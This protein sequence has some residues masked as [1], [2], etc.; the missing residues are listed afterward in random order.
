MK[1]KEIHFVLVIISFTIIVA[2]GEVNKGHPRI[3][4]MEGGEEVIQEQISSND[5]WAGIHR[6][7]IEESEGMLQMEPLE[8]K[9]TGRRLL[10][11]SR[12]YLRRIFYL[13]YAYRMTDDV[14]FAEHAE[15]HMLKAAGFPDWNPSHF[16]DVGEMTMAI[17]IG[18]DWL[19]HALSD[20]SKTMI[21][22]AIVNK[23]IEPSFNEEYNWFLDAEHN[24]NQVCNAGMAYGAMAVMEDYPQLAD[25][26]IN[27]AFETIPKAMA[28]YQ[29]DG[30]YPEGYSYWGYGTTFNVLFLSV[31]ETYFGT[32]RGLSDTPGF[33]ETAGFL[34]H[35][36]APSGDCF[37]WGDCGSDG[38]LKPAMF[39]FAEK[40]ND[41]SLLWMEK[42]FLQTNDFTKFTRNRI[43][44]AIMVWGR[45]IDVDEI[46]P[47]ASKVWVGQGKNPVGLMRTSWSDNAMYLG[48]KVGSPSVNHGHMDIGSFVFENDGIRWAMDFGLQGYH[49][50]ESKGMN[51][52]GRTQDAERWTIFRL[53]NY[54]HNTLTIDGQL[55]RVDGYANIDHY[56]DDDDFMY[57]VSDI[58]S[59][60][61]GQLEQATR[62]TGIVNGAYAIIR[63]EV[64][65]LNN[66]SL[67]RW[68]MVTPAEVQLTSKGA[69][70]TK[71]GKKMYL[72]V[73]G[74]VT[75]KM[76][77]WSTAPTTDYDAE[78]PETVMV[79]FVYRLPADSAVETE[80]LLIPEN[81]LDKAE[82]VNMKL[83]EW[84]DEK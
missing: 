71:D 64:K 19:F 44:P 32:D 70:L 10:G 54:A 46:N 15:K 7:I 1:T 8:R 12:E 21:K 35:M 62:G 73:K 37:N 11:V 3:L 56:S 49:S 25:S 43:L 2:C 40:N 60:Y 69:V 79:G 61:N 5:I 68:N 53:N 80:V 67:V 36:V 27:R 55:Q 31:M 84:P 9:K 23:G 24:W 28:D 33:L 14:R 72:K 41:P 58:S 82:F 81:T 34:K 18:Y 13:S 51:I 77:T 48:F 63:D 75:L 83:S 16:L 57:V 22:E 26:V 38:S 39:W 78:N 76:K 45:N 4:L 30:A 47:P 20:E 29:P 6:V 42:K 65:S 52:F 74:P 50:L 17:A 66:T 59:V